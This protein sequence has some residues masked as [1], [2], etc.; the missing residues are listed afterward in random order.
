MDKFSSLKSIQQYVQNHDV[1]FS[2]LITLVFAVHEGILSC[3]SID[4]FYSK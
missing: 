4:F 1:I 2:D 3:L